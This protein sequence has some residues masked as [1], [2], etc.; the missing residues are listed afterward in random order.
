MLRHEQQS[1]RLALAECQH[2]SAQRQK[3]A[4]AGEGVRVEVHGQVPDEPPSQERQER[5][6]G[7][8]F[9]LVLDT[10][11]QQLE[12]E[13]DV[14]KVDIPVPGSKRTRGGFQSLH[15]GQRSTA[16]FR[17]LSFQLLVKVFKI[18]SQFRILQPLPHFCVKSRL[19]GFFALFPT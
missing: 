18:F 10:A 6:S 7:I 19:E 8:G 11:V 2:H 16:P 15:P 13:L 4:R 17:S 3:T 1:I 5:H 12:R 9:E 14:Q